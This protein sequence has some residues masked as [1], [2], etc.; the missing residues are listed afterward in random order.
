MRK[1]RL[2]KFA[3]RLT[4]LL[5]EGTSWHDGIGIFHKIAELISGLFS[6]PSIVRASYACAEATA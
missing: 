4:V 6:L 1:Q 5:C 2:R 3:M